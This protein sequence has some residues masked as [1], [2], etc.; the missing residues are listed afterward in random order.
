MGDGDD[1]C[2]WLDESDNEYEEPAA[3]EG[4]HSIAADAVVKPVPVPLFE[5]RGKD[6]AKPVETTFEPHG[7]D[8]LTTP[9]PKRVRTGHFTPTPPQAGC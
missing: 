2:V 9:P 3:D 4:F 1:A 5:V 7:D 6:L 8:V